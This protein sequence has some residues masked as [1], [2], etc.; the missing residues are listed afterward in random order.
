MDSKMLNEEIQ[1]IL[2]EHEKALRSYVE[3]LIKAN[4]TARLTGPSDA[5][6]LWQNHIID[7]AC[8]VP[9]LPLGGRVIDVGTGGG[10]PG[11]VWAIARPDLEFTLLD[12]IAKKMAQ[13]EKIT[14][15]LGLKNVKT[16]CERSED[17]AKEHG[18]KFAVTAARAVTAAGILAELLSPFAKIGGKIISF[19]GPKVAEELE[20]V[21]N[22]WSE[23][24]LSAPK[25]VPYSYDDKKRYLLTWEKIARGPKGIPRRP[26]MAEKFPWYEMHKTRKI[27]SKKERA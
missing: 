3:H 8:A 26:G 15:L 21:G 22:R 17:Y 20:T 1:K 16:I 24:G 18:E 25:L 9:L 19:K 4:E 13:V 23:L 6:T 5:E 7:C 12:S 11:I 27:T 10:L 2:T 14:T